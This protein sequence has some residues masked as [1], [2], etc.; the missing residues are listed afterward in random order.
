MVAGPVADPGAAEEPE[1]RRVTGLF[2]AVW[3]STAC[4]EAVRALPCPDVEGIRWEPVGL[5]HVTLRYV[6]TADPADVASA[7]RRH[8]LQAAT[9]HLGPAVELL[10][11]SV[12]CVPVGGLDGLAAAVIAATGHLGDPVP[13]RD[14]VGHVTLGRL[15][16][17]R[18]APSAVTRG[19]AHPA[20]PPGLGQPSGARPDGVVGHGIQC[21]FAV[22]SVAL[23]RSHPGRPGGTGR[24]YETLATFDLVGEPSG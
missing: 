12:V 11:A 7:L 5:E 24:R 15:G 2:V 13:E 1:R 6:G 18:H 4:V 17:Q 8:P 19:D 10:G 3:P 14:F 22:R 20:R 23:V 21:S 16:L 9:A